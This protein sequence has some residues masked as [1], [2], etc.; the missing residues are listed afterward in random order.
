[1]A[2]VLTV[3]AGRRLGAHAHRVNHHH[4]WVLNGRA[5]I[6]GTELGPGSYVDIPSGVETTST[7]PRPA[8]ARS[9]TCTSATLTDPDGALVASGGRSA[10]SPPRH[11]VEWDVS[12][13]RCADGV[14]QGPCRRRPT[15]GGT[16]ATSARRRGRGRPAP[17]WGSGGGRGGEGARRPAR[18]DRGPQAG[19]ALPARAGHG[20]HRRGRRPRRQRRGRAPGPGHRRRA[21]RGR[22][23]GAGRARPAGQPLPC[24][25]QLASR[26]RDGWW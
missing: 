8:G 3:E 18:R 6:L 22:S 16:A 21:G 7:F 13:R 26:W 20:R 25:A 1:M 17:R 14:V 10:L 15:P 19:C 11:R 23:T 5:T 12:I 2:G 4:L 24:R 9:S